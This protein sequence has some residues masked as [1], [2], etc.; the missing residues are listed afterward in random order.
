MSD[1]HS[2]KGSIFGNKYVS[3]TSVSKECCYY[4]VLMKINK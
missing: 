3:P 2:L 1:L 4:I